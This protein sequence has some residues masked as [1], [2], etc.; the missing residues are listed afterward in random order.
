MK[1][2]AT[3]YIKALQ[4]VRDY[5]DQIKNEAM[6]VT[7]SS[8]ILDCSF[9]SRTLNALKG[10]LAKRN[11]NYRTCTLLDLSKFS[12]LEIYLTRNIGEATLADIEYHLS[13]EN[14]NLKGKY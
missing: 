9:E 1:I 5:A 3:Q 8:F 12:R 13:L 4:I 7:G 6:E 14:L 10:F 11:I 2:T